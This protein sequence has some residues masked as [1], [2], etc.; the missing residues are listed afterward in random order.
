MI[1][2]YNGNVIGSRIVSVE[3][4]KSKEELLSEQSRMLYIKGVEPPISLDVLECIVGDIAPVS[5]LNPLSTQDLN[6]VIKV[7]DGLDIEGVVISCSVFD[8]EYQ[9]KNQRNCFV[10]NI[11]LAWSDDELL[12]YCM[13]F[14]DVDSAKLRGPVEGPESTTQCGYVSFVDHKVSKRIIEDSVEERF[15]NV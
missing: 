7:L 13:R 5:S 11:P 9:E 10:R 8:S 6:R 15:D 4:K 12:H 3:Y 1:Q 2:K 14:G